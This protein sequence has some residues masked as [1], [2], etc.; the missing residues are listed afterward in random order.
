VLL[1]AENVVDSADMMAA[2]QEDLGGWLYQF[3]APRAP[4]KSLGEWK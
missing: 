2:H 3:G 1:Q 4:L